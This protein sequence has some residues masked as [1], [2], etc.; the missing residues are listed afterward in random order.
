MELYCTEQIG[1]VKLVKIGWQE[2]NPKSLAMKL[3]FKHIFDKWVLN[4]GYNSCDIF[5]DLGFWQ[6]KEMITL[7]QK[8]S[9]SQ[10]VLMIYFCLE[11]KTK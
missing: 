9:P 3:R 10:H 8:S 6:L 7:K 5:G 2:N 11:F 1:H 4:K